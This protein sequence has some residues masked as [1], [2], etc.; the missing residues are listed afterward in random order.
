[1]SPSFSLKVGEGTLYVDGDP[2]IPTAA[3]RIF[4]RQ[5]ADYQ[6]SKTMQAF[7]AKRVEFLF[8][9]GDGETVRY[10]TDLRATRPKTEPNRK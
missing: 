6:S 7:R 5:G 9:I 2:V 10:Q 1:M 8:G 4:V 3:V